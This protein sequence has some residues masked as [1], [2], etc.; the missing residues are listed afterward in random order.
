[1]Q[2][3]TF[4]L[5]GFCAAY[6]RG[7]PPILAHCPLAC[8][9]QL[10]YWSVRYTT[11]SYHSSVTI[12]AAPSGTPLPYLSPADPVHT[13]PAP[14]TIRFAGGMVVPFGLPV[15]GFDPVGVPGV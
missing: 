3:R 8:E 14:S 2:F 5:H 13:L 7:S 4:Y 11:P 15:H 1:M 12:K 10:R 6:P 9:Y